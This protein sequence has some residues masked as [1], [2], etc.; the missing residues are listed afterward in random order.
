MREEAL[1]RCN[2]DHI[3][4]GL[5]D[6]LKDLVQAERRGIE[7]RLDH[8]RSRMEDGELSSP[9]APSR[10]EMERLLRR[11]NE[12]SRRS[13]EFLDGLP[14][15]PA[16]AIGR[17]RE[18]EFTEEGARTS[19]EDLI[20]SLQ[21]RALDSFFSGLSQE[22]RSAS[23]GQISFLN[24]M[25]GELNEVLEGHLNAGE[26]PGRTPFDRFMQRYGKL[27]GS[28]PPASVEEL[29][30]EM[31][32][33]Q[34]QIESLLKSL[35][36]ELRGELEAVIGAL[37][38]EQGLGE[39]MARLAANL[40]MMCQGSMVAEGFLF[41]GLEPLGLE[42]A[43]EMMRFLQRTEELERQLKRTQQGHQLD[44]VDT[45]LLREVMGEEIY[46]AAEQL[47]C[48]A[49]ALEDAGYVRRDGSRYE[50]TPKG[51]RKV[52]QKALQEIFSFIGKDRLGPHPSRST[53][54]GGDLLEA[55][56]K[57]QFGDPF[58]VNLR[59]SLMNAVQ[60][61][62]GLPVRVSPED[63]EIHETEELSQAATVL[64]LDLSLSMVMRGNFPVAKKVALALDN[65]IRTQF[66][67]DSLHVV[68]F[69]TYAREVDPEKLATLSW[70]ESD[71]YTNIQHG[72][73]VARKL[74]A[75]SRGST[76]QIIVISDGEP[77]AHMEGRQ[78]FLQY[79][80]SPR[81]IQETLKEVQRCTRQDIRINTFMLERSS[82]LVEFVDQMT[83]I[84]RGRVFYTSR[85]KL[86]EYILVD[87]LTSRR[88]QLA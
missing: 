9:S 84:N 42:E 52:G 26:S 6:R 18:Y 43:L 46:Q 39:E 4:D 27:F 21:Q 79:P 20:K 19:F 5:K 24:G 51:I 86:G 87:Y 16:E 1:D 8:A 15:E 3:L 49:E 57:Y 73:K 56:K 85:D 34:A 47:M 68:G 28:N 81:T 74:L 40:D 83:R 70:D 69:S 37:F 62:G 35:S 76:R 63:F 78:L 48:M 12:M 71:P 30:E 54:A 36:P 22:L 55:T 65:L 45:E 64:M 2:L 7:Q 25:L 82:Y 67:R 13:R 31:Y 72:L 38:R 59:R 11:L 75:G 44:S 66:P 60:R 10:R 23:P 29:A 32:R 14:Q 61:D 58:H 41:R 50:L 77:T 88:R 33:Q 17:L 53:G 80:P